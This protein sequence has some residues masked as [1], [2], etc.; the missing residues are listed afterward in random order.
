MGISERKFARVA[1]LTVIA[2][3]ALTGLAAAATNGTYTGNSSQNGKSYPFGLKVSGGK[4]VA[5]AGAA[6]AKC[7]IVYATKK[8]PFS[9]SVPIRHNSFSASIKLNSGPAKGSVLTLSGSFQG[10][11][12]SGSF[13]GSLAESGKKCSIPESSFHASR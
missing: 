3:L 9:L 6:S 10:S 11:S 2:V 13:G 8:K 7:G 12:V 1:V 5:L 4:I